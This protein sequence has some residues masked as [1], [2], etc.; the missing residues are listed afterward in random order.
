MDARCRPISAGARRRSLSTTRERPICDL[1]VAHLARA[2]ARTAISSMWVLGWFADFDKL[3]MR[4]RMMM[5]LFAVDIERDRSAFIFVGDWMNDEPMSGFYSIGVAG[6]Q[7]SYRPY[8]DPTAL[9]DKAKAVAAL[10]K[11]PTRCFKIADRR[12]SGRRVNLR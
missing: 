2:G 4:R 1:L 6:V 12:I 11:L 5:E 8:G 3:A 9:G 10:S 7:T